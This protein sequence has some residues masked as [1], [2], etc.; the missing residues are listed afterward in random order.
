MKWMMVG[1]LLWGAGAKAQVPVIGQVVSTVV[2]AADLVVQ[3]LQTETIVLQEAEQELQNAMSAV[4][5]DDIANWVDDQ[6][7]LYAEYFAELGQ[8]KTVISGYYK[9]AEMVDR[10]KQILAAYERG[11][12]LFR[13]DT[14][15]SVA[16]LEQIETVYGGILTESGKNLSQLMMVLQ[17]LTTQMTDEQRMAIIDG[18]AAGM[19]ATY[20]DLQAYTNGNELLSLQRAQDENDYAVVKQLYGL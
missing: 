8:V 19:D 11:L 9:V 5:L 7:S 16:E 1:V 15:F 18:A 17:S 6:R 13:Q 20:R 12:A 3:R 14:H 4:Q 10:Q 2:R